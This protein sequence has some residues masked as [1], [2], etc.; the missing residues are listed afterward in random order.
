MVEEKCIW[1]QMLQLRKALK[2]QLQGTF[3]FVCFKT[4]TTDAFLLTLFSEMPFYLKLSTQKHSAPG[5]WLQ[6]VKV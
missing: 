1:R 5:P 6:K 3:L 4:G 2:T